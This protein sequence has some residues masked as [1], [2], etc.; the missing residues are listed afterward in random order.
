MQVEIYEHIARQ[1]QPASR[2]SLTENHNDLDSPINHSTNTV[3]IVP[4]VSRLLHVHQ[5]I[6]VKEDTCILQ[7]N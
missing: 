3:A 1:I 5:V 2:Q 6:L 7:S 4:F